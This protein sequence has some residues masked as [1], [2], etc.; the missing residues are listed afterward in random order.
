MKWC[1]MVILSITLLLAGPLSAVHLQTEA[2]PLST[3]TVGIEGQLLLRWSGD[4][5]EVAPIPDDSPVLVRIASITPGEGQEQVYDL[6][7]IAMLPGEHHLS[8]LLRYGEGA[9]ASELPPLT[10]SVS[11]LLQDDHEGG[12][13]Q[14][15]GPISPI[16]GFP[17]WVPWAVAIGWLLL[18]LSILTL[19]RWLRKP[20]PPAPQPIA[21]P[22]LAELLRPLVS[23]ALAGE[24][25]DAQKARMERI[26]LAHWREDLNLGSYRHGEGIQKLR[27]HP[28]AGI[29]LVTVEQWLHSGR[30]EAVSEKQL[31]DLL[32]PYA[33]PMA[34]PIEEAS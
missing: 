25:D 14:I 12:L 20:P 16:L 18:P 29:L 4:P 5:L 10:I 32:A 31:E 3:G 23:A 26:L 27:T 19:V 6:R 34:D 30:E 8:R 17:E 21:P 2:D 9:A 33:T 22:T 11:S 13:N 28:E 15:P 24:L 7:W 1:P